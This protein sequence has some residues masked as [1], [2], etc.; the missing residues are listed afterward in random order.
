[1]SRIGSVWQAAP[2]GLG[3]WLVRRY[4]QPW[5][6]RYELEVMALLEDS[7]VRWR[8][9]VDLAR[10][11]VVE[12]ARALVEPGEHPDATFWLLGFVNLA[13]V[14][15]MALAPVGLGWAARAGFGPPP[16]TWGRTGY[17][18]VA[19]AFTGLIV[20]LMVRGTREVMWG[21]KHGTSPSPRPQAEP[22]LAIVLGIAI[23][24]GFLRSWSG[25]HDYLASLFVMQIM[26]SGR[27]KGPGWRIQSVMLQLAQCRHE[28]KWARLE[29]D[30]CELLTAQGMPAPLDDARANVA[31]I[32][33]EREQA[34][35]ELHANGY[36]AKFR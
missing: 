35:A 9:V 7:S 6:A 31:R 14:G 24:G 10:G 13:I 27:W 21:F 19:G 17:V 32:E 28:M 2:Q 8:D 33:R 30:R 20:L 15:G 36:R 11:L 5:R 22:R 12:R 34:L 26:L 16:A 3:R 29:L 23:L 25:V 1:M 4:P 18:L